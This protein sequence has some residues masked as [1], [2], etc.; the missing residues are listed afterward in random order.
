MN[1][2]TERGGGGRGGGRG[3][4]RGEVRGLVKGERE[5]G[6]GE[7][8][9]ERE[10]QRKGRGKG[11]TDLYCILSNNSYTLTCSKWKRARQVHVCIVREGTSASERS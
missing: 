5:K 1:T 3:E 11:C 6:W 7:R 10:R 4:E 9:R 2:W 8:E